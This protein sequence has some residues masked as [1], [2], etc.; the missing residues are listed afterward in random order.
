M[1]KV[2]RKIPA[3]MATQH[4]DHANRPYWYKDAFIPAVEEARESFLSFS[5]LGISEYKWDWEG[6][7]VDESVLER[8][9]A[10]HFDYFKKYPIGKEKFLTFRLP[11]PK[12][13]TE[14]R[15]SRALMGIASAAGLAKQV[16]LHSPP[17]F[18]VILPMTETAEE[19]VSIQ[20]A[21]KEIA[22]LRH[23][24]NKMENGC[25]VFLEIIPLFESVDIILNSYKILEKYLRL[26]HKKFNS[27]PEYLR[28][29]V[30]RSDPALNSGLVPTI[31][32]IKVALSRYKKFEHKHNLPMF[33][34]IGVGTLPFRGG[35]NPQRPDR[36]IKEYPGV[37]TTIIQSAFRY[38]FP[39]K[40]VIKAIAKLEKELP[41]THTVTINKNEETKLI[42]TI[43]YFEKEYQNTIPGIAP[44]INKMASFMP[45]RR[46]RVQHVGLFGYS[47]GVGKVKLPRAISY[48]AALYSLGI[49]PELIGT[50]R[51]LAK[52]KKDGTLNL[53]EKHYVNLKH[54]LYFAGKFL[55]KPGLEA[56]AKK[57]SA[58]GK[59]LQDVI[60]IE[61]YLG[62]PLTA[63][64]L[65][66]QEHQLISAKIHKLI[67]GKKNI[68]PLIEQSALLRK[69]LG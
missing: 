66:E 3:T 25:D 42:K 52:A 54:D 5:E 13:Q 23:P 22:C 35:I 40:M 17:L 10:S 29:Y 4:P 41:K 7:L 15:L 58:W 37:R 28:P 60:E 61:N 49:P 62:E 21:F 30:A 53:V 65:N 16:G 36:F 11:N 68:T 14:F 33:P 67:Q 55:Y 51:G 43:R 18:E 44:L 32:S 20:E 34:V 56:L 46:E 31:L 47:R 69:S 19:M 39:K 6:K 9:L 45:K 48:T 59:I 50:G 64:Y 63:K 12:V 38:D 2:Q 27:R 8:L 57:S 26:Y 1:Q 24:L